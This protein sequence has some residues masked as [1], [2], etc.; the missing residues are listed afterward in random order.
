MFVLIWIKIE[1]PLKKI[2]CHHLRALCDCFCACSIYGSPYKHNYL[3]VVSFTFIAWELSACLVAMPFYAHTH[4]QTL[5]N[6]CVHIHARTDKLVLSRIAHYRE[7]MHKLINLWFT[8]FHNQYAFC[9][10]SLTLLYL[11]FLNYKKR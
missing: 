5:A 6:T 10:A 9:P 2:I 3:V 8:V 7:C 4:T 1:N 11:R